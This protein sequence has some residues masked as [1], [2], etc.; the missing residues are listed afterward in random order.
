M[1]FRNYDSNAGKV[2]L[3]ESVD[4]DELEDSKHRKVTNKRKIFLCPR[5]SKKLRQKFL[6]TVTTGR[7]NDSRQITIDYYYELAKIWDGSPASE[8]LSYGSSATCVNDNINMI[9]V[10]VVVIAYQIALHLFTQGYYIST[11][12]E[13]FSTCVEFFHIIA[14]FFNSVYQA[15]ISTQD[16]NLRIILT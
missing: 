5:E 14:I 9:P 15:E 4:E 11:W 13:I 3:C 7:R 12:V 10:A 16:K 8:P 2:K 6:E 1:E